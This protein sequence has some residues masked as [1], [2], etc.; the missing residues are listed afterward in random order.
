MAAPSHSGLEVVGVAE[1]NP[2]HRLCHCRL[3]LRHDDQVNVVRHQAKHLHNILPMNSS[4]CIIRGTPYMAGPW[5]CFA[6]TDIAT[7]IY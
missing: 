2:S 5:P 3:V 6:A 4:L 1:V 7:A